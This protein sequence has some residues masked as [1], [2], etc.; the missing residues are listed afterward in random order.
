MGEIVK[1]DFLVDSSQFNNSL[2][3]MQQNLNCYR[4][5]VLQ[6]F[7]SIVFDSFLNNLNSLKNAIAG[8]FGAFLSEAEKIEDV[9]ARLGVMLGGDAAGGEKLAHSLERLATNGVVPLQELEQAAA[10]LSSRF[11]STADI[12]QW[13]SVCA[14]I[15]AGSKITATR[16]AE[17]TA[18]LDD[19]GKAEF[20]ELANAGID[21][22]STRL[23][24]SHP[25][26]SRM[27]SSA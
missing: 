15:S 1:F 3:T 25:V 23:N 10:A 18:R 13:V 6:G 22:K 26:Q 27:P 11:A 9:A 24:S 17:M 12:S 5:S 16:L 14:D 4:Q 7:N 20:T 21:R 8:T 2:D 19:M